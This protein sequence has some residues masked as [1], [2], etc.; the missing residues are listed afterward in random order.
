MYE[1]KQKGYAETSLTSW[2]FDNQ[3]RRIFKKLLFFNPFSSFEWK[4]TLVCQYAES[5]D[6]IHR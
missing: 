5:I 4:F 3:G 1:K 2:T 6:T